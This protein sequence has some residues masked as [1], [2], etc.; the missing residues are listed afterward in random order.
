MRLYSYTGLL[1]TKLEIANSE[2]DYVLS[3]SGNKRQ[4]WQYSFASALHS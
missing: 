2:V 4:L 3:P 1:P